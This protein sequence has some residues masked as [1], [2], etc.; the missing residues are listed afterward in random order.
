M[1]RL[2]ENNG[3]VI[4]FR[5]P[6]NDNFTSHITLKMSASSSNIVPEMNLPSQYWNAISQEDR[7][8]F[9]RLRNNFHHGQKISSKDRRIITFSKELNIVL[10]FLER[11]EDNQEARCVLCGVCF[12]GPIVC[13][14]TRQLKSFLSRCKSSINGS[15][16]QLGFV[17]LRTK[18][19]ARNCVLTALPSLQN[20][21]NIL[22]QWTVRYASDDARFCF[23]SSYSNLAMPEITPDDLFDE[24]KT[25]PRRSTSSNFF[26]PPVSQHMPQFPFNMAQQQQ[27]QLTA[28]QLQGMT[29][30]QVQQVTQQSSPNLQAGLSAGLQPGMQS[31]LTST[32][33]QS[34]GLQS[35]LTSG[36]QSNLAASILAAKPPFQPKQIEFDL[37]S[38]DDFDPMEPQGLEIPNFTSSLSYECFQDLDM[39][40]PTLPGDDDLINGDD[41]KTLKRSHS[42]FVQMRGE[43]DFLS[44]NFF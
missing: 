17:A 19:K 5:I 43:W 16:Q 29:P 3:F 21:Q 44:D 20:H 39:E 36:L 27:Q 22:R 34:S 4:N 18:A 26:L 11:S 41:D 42:A 12:V 6:I 30:Q 31:N 13:V 8:E 7:N 32:T 37:Q 35:N 33:L 2:I 9:L 40:P 24:K 28:Q 23:V 38:I 14:N 25:A 15:F 10:R 1:N